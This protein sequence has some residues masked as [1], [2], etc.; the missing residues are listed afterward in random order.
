MAESSIVV[1]PEPMDSS[2]YSAASRLQA[3]GL[4][5]ATAIFE[6]A[7]DA[8]PLPDPSQSIMI[9]DYGAA[10]GY[11]SLLPIGAAIA[12]LRKRTRSE[13]PVLVTHT[14][15]PD[16]DFS[17]L[18]HTLEN[19]PDTYLRKDKATYAAAVGRSFYSQILPSNSVHL[20][21]SSWA[22]HWLTRVPCAIEGH[23]QVNFCTDDAVRSAFARQ[24]AEDW[25]E[26]VAFRGRE[27]CPGGRL[28]VMTM[29]VGD[30]DDSGFRPLMSALTDTLGELTGDGL[31]T[32]DETG[33][34][35]IPTVARRAADFVAPFAPSGRFE[36]LEIEHLEIFDAT[37]RFWDRYCKDRDARAFGAKWAAFA[38]ASV[39]P[40]LALAL[41]EGAADSRTAEF[42]DRLERGVAERMSRSPEQT[43]IPLAHVVLVK[44]R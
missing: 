22:I 31:L 32:A 3:A 20:G 12:R 36:R 10:N 11:N 42:F 26:F 7:A 41:H 15:R 1:R 13:H 43:R 37:D 9:A 6:R 2:S 30:D 25:H 18:F 35:C 39:F 24:A 5:A 23:I 27:L 19:D 38:R 29:A 28:V 14:D 16:N 21:W 34:M 33:R 17:A 8:V 4:Q 44:R 40:A